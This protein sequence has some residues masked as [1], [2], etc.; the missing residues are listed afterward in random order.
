MSVN[1]VVVF[2]L[3]FDLFFQISSIMGF[4]W[5]F[6]YVAGTVNIDALWYV[7]V[8]LNSLQGVFIF[9]SFGFNDRVREMARVALMAKT[10]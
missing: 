3:N 5:L 6:G 7:F 10:R 8:V 4:S 1:L 9:M 2:G